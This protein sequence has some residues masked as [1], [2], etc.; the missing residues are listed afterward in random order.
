MKRILIQAV[1]YVLHTMKFWLP[2]A[3]VGGLIFFFA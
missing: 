2:L 1:G 3:V